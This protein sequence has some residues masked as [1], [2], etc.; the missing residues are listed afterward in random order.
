MFKYYN[1]LGFNNPYYIKKNGK[2]IIKSNISEVLNEF[3]SIHEVDPVAVIEL[4]F[5]TYIFTLLQHM[6][7]LVSQSLVLCNKC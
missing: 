4:F 2:F 7:L 3:N 5:K 6:C 1:H